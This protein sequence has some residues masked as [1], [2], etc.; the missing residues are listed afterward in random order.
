ME[1][2]TILGEIVDSSGRVVVLVSEVT[3]A[4]EQQ[5][6]GIEQASQAVTQ[7]DHS[8]RAS[9]ASAEQSA[10]AG[11]DLAAQAVEMNKMVQNLVCLIDGKVKI[12]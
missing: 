11:E 7:L 12:K 3:E 6:I 5:S 2:A 9:V 4:S 8:A 1:A 10:G